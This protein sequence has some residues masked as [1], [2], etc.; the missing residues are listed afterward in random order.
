V[1]LHNAQI[2]GLEHLCQIK[3]GN[4]REKTTG[5]FDIVFANLTAD[6]L[7]LLYQDISTVVHSGTT[8][9]LSRI[10]D[11]KLD[12]IVELFSQK[13]DVVETKQKGEWRALKLFAK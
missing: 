6:S 9:I 5:T 1:A 7:Q 2:S 10:L 11:S 13:F 8:L 4:L 12:G 3:T